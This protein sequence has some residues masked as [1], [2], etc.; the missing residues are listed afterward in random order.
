MMYPIAPEWLSGA[1]PKE[2]SHKRLKKELNFI[3]WT[4]AKCITNF[5]LILKKQRWEES[6]L[7]RLGAKWTH[8]HK[9]I[10]CRHPTSFPDAPLGFS[11]IAE[12][13]AQQS[14]LARVAW[15]R[16]RLQSWASVLSVRL[17]VWSVTM[18]QRGRRLG[19]LGWFLMLCPALLS[20]NLCRI[21]V[22]S[23]LA[24]KMYTLGGFIN[25]FRPVYN[26]PQLGFLFF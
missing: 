8:S 14:R 15:V 13:A 7:S 17:W 20:S 6:V 26:Y 4:P 21:W 3:Y 19:Q 22:C 18:Q 5:L 9:F 23:S 10:T 25:I 12:M 2:Q 1:Q 16:P 11:S 24:L